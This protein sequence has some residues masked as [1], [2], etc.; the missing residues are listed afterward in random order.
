MGDLKV[1]ANSAKNNNNYS[2]LDTLALQGVQPFYGF[3]VDVGIRRYSR[4]AGGSAEGEFVGFVCQTRPV[5]DRCIAFQFLSRVAITVGLKT[6][7]KSL[8]AHGGVEETAQLHKSRLLRI[9]G[10][11]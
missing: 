11:R 2:H 6:S 4:L 1:W 7:C 5:N 3:V 10:L 9:A 8:D